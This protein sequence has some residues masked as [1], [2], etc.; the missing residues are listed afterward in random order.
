MDEETKQRIRT[1]GY[2]AGK[3]AGKLTEHQFF[4]L[5]C[6]KEQDDTKAFL[7]EVMKE[8]TGGLVSI[9]HVLNQQIKFRLKKCEPFTNTKGGTRAGSR[10]YP[11]KIIRWENF[12]LLDNSLG[13]DFRA[14]SDEQRRSAKSVLMTLFEK[15]S[16][17]HNDIRGANFGVDRD[18]GNVL[19]F[20]LEDVSREFVS[21]K[22][23]D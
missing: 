15:F 5:Q 18:S 11:K 2:N 9:K 3:V 23:A 20:D 14:W 1:A 17:R 10:S 13:D 19:V 6:F 21:K 7:D 22:L 4:L 12:E 16:I 8:S